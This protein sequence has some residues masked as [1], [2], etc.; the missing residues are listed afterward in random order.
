MSRRKR[1]GS[2]QRNRSVDIA[3]ETAVWPAA[4]IFCPPLPWPK[5][6]RSQAAASNCSAN[7]RPRIPCPVADEASGMRPTGVLPRR[8]MASRDR[9]QQMLR[10]CLGRIHVIY[11]ILKYT[12]SYSQAGELVEQRT[13]LIA[14][15]IA[16]H[17]QGI[18]AWSQWSGC[19]AGLCHLYGSQH[20]KQM[21]NAI[22]GR[23]HKLLHKAG[24][25]NAQI[26]TQFG[27]QIRDGAKLTQRHLTVT[28]WRRRNG[29]SR[30]E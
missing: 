14:L 2:L 25:W 30:R 17:G 27:Q 24:E 7:M 29:T 12:S 6:W 5:G 15:W 1:T 11:M 16:W 18:C 21:T 28:L 26:C 8:A 9:E 19:I 22:R 23:G 4:L 13:A 3:S 10:H 20:L